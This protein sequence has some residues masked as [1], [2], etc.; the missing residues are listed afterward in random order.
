MM[1]KSNRFRNNQSIPLPHG[2]E[3]STDPETRK[4]FFIDHNSRT[5]QWIDPRDR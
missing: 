3:V 2:W 5:T 1:P 4:V